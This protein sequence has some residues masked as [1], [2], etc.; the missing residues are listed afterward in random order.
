MYTRA[1]VRFRP[2]STQLQSFPPRSPN[3]CSRRQRP[4]AVKEADFQAAEEAFDVVS[5][6]LGL[7][8]DPDGVEEGFAAL[9]EILRLKP[10]TKVVVA[11][12]PFVKKGAARRSAYVHGSRQ[13]HSVEAGGRLCAR[14]SLLSIGS[15]LPLYC[16]AAGGAA[17]VAPMWWNTCLASG[18]NGAPTKT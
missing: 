6:D 10:D 17:R 14:Q 4:F 18:R 15:V 3:G 9:T 13:E 7:P 5:L 2:L 11:S 16:A 12:T 8:L 1:A